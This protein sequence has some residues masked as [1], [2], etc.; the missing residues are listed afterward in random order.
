V[1]IGWNPTASTGMPSSS[2]TI[3]AKV[4]VDPWPLSGAAVATVTDELPVMETRA[5]AVSDP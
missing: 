2:A 4:V 1:S 3:W 5:L